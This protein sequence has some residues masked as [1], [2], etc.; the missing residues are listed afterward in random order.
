MIHPS[1]DLLGGRVVQLRGGNPDDCKVAIDDVFGVAEQFHRHGEL[2][3]IDLD[4]ALG[5]GDNLELI[6]SLCARFDCRVGGGIRDHARADRVLRAG[7]RKIIIGTRAEPAFLSRYPRERLIVALDARAGRVVDHGWTKTTGDSVLER[8]AALAPYCSE[9]LYT[10][11]DREGS[12]QGI[13]LAAIAELVA[14]TSNHVVAAGGIASLQEVV[15]LD[16]MGASC[17]LGMSIYTGVV[18][19]TDAFMAMLQWNRYDGGHSGLL[20][21]VV[22][23]EADQV[24][25]SAWVDREALAMTLASGDACYYSRSRAQHWRKGAT[26]GHTQRVLAVRYDCDRD[27][28]LY[29]VAQ[30]GQACHVPDRYSCFGDQR[31]SLERLEATLQGRKRAALSGAA[32]DSYSARLMVEAGLCEAKL[33]EEAEELGAATNAREIT[34]EAADVLYFTLARLVREGVPLAAVLRELEGRVG[35]R[36]AADGTMVAGAGGGARGESSDDA[37]GPPQAG[38]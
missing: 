6:A 8:A 18:S 5:R 25:M 34:W 19:L 10:L 37:G 38:Q 33:R 24:V 20:P 13:D 30:Q 22:Q 31:F 35:R 2:A 3:V 1:I 15:E 16:R 32:G 4:A 14:A 36:R 7:A 12:L 21:V 28:L 29:R 11:V 9:F 27:A 23:D 26:S 17:Q